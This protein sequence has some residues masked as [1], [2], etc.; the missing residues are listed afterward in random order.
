MVQDCGGRSKRSTSVSSSAVNSRCVLVSDLGGVAARQDLAVHCES[1][2]DDVGVGQPARRQVVAQRFTGREQ[3]RPQAGVLADGRT[4]RGAVGRG[5]Q[6]PTA[7][8]FRLGQRLLLVAG[9]RAA[10]GR[11]DPDLQ[12]VGRLVRRGI[13]L[14]VQDALAGAHALHLAAPDDAAV[15]EAVLVL[16]GAVEN[17]RDDL[18]VAVAVHAEAAA[19]RDA[20]LVDHAQHAP[21]HVVRILIFG[22]GE[23][24][25]RLQPA[26]VGE[27]AFGGKS[28]ADHVNSL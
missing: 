12:Q 2:A 20:I 23:A 28:W 13:E 7:T 24:V 4:A 16:E 11:L 17:V 10:L 21:A 1:T 15:A 25:A 3:R 19:R 18:H 6:A 26:V 14:A 9:A 22:E 5:D 27:A 8:Q